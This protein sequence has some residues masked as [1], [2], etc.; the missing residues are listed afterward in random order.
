MS[1][2]HY[3][4][5]FT[6]IMGILVMFTGGNS[7]MAE[8][9]VIK[10]ME[11]GDVIYREGDSIIVRFAGKRHVLG[12]ALYNGGFRQNLTA[13]LNHCT[14]DTKNTMTLASYQNSMHDLCIKLGYNPDKVMTLGTSVPMENAVIC[15]EK[16]KSLEITAIVTAGAE[17]NPGRAGDNA[18]YPGLEIKGSPVKGTINIMI[19]FN[20]D[21]PEGV[22]ARAIMTST[23]AKTAALQE[24]MIGSR[25]SDGLATG[26]GTDQI[27]I[28]SNPDSPLYVTDC[29]VHT[30]P[31]EILGRIVKKAVKEALLK[32]NGFN[33]AKMHSVFRR[34]ERFG[35]RESVIKIHYKEMY[36]DD[37][38]PETFQKLATAIDQK[39]DIVVLTSLFAHLTD[40]YHWGL[41]SFDEAKRNG[42]RILK[43]IVRE[44]DFNPGNEKNLFAMYEKAYLILLNK[45]SKK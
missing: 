23:E 4:F 8:N 35:F 30:K 26:T 16:Y 45:E 37:L 17:G 43:E 1:I 10:C 9:Q 19:L 2:N 13:V 12:S 5:L 25:Y 40:Q 11:N 29:G 42:L 22:L 7:I 31:G 34:M 18:F 39:E 33:A 38:S 3:K 36:G 27:L 14:S 20:A 28:V 41:I 44:D 32:Q 15:S 21:M 24:L 6:I